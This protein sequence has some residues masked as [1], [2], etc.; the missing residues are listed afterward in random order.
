MT[1]PFV[2]LRVHSE[3]SL[4]DSLVRIKPL[5][6]RCAD[7]QMPALAL[8]DFCNMFALVKFQRATIDAG[9][10]PIYGADVLVESKF[11]DEPASQIVL[12]AKSLQGY[13]NLTELVS[14]AYLHGQKLDK[15]IIS[16]AYLSQKTEGL[17]CLSGGK[18]AEIG[19]ALLA[20]KQ[21][22]AEQLV[23]EYNALFPDSFYLELHRTGRQDDET[24]LHLAVDLA[25]TR[26]ADQDQCR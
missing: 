15:A 19:R 8:T 12:L 9:I 23:E 17:I 21:A 24:Y 7:M 14:E 2:H 25:A 20:G 3:Y 10:K 18:D 6:K 5:A 16:R 4:V 22:K 26:E 11:P 1:Q 13:R